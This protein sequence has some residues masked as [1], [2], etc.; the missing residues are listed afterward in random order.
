[1]TP[2]SSRPRPPDPRLAG[3]PDRRGR[4]RARVG[5]ARTRRGAVGR[6]DRARTRR[7]S[8]ATAAQDWGGKGVMRAV[9]NV[10]GEL[11]AAVR[12]HGRRRPA[13]AS[14]RALDRGRR[15]A[16]QGAPRGE[17]DSRR[18]AR[19]GEGGRRRRGRVALPL[20][21][22]AS[23]ARDAARA[24]DERRSTA[25]RTRTTRSTCRSSWSC[26]PAHPPSRRGC[27]SATRCSTRCARCCTSA[28]SRRRSATRAG[29]RPTSA[30]RE[31]AIERILEAAERAGHRDHVAIALDPAS[32][33]VLRGRRA[34]ASRGARRDGAGMADFY[35][36]L[37][38][39]VS[40]RLGRGRRSRR[41]TGT[42]GAR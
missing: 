37:A 36:G 29:S 34:T 13:R 6:V 27:G 31:E 24:D 32:S 21:S 18:L 8:C 20:R 40:A 5:R 10:R 26:R 42:R 25:A 28:G 9:A 11:A 19:D 23:D 3:Q 22:A 39:A 2:I 17:R 14:T 38:D 41:T 15:D 1:M 33:R 4:R 35:A 7:S 30:R 12:G 16:E